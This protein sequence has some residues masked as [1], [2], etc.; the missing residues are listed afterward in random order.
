MEG[1]FALSLK[2][3]DRLRLIHEVE[4]GYISGTEAAEALGISA[5]QFKRIR[6]RHREEGD[7]G[8]AHRVSPYCP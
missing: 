6:R 5:R 3:R 1:T 7:K 4:K 8:I 2:E